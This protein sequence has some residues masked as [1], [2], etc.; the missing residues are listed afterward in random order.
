[1]R[2]KVDKQSLHGFK[3]KRLLKL[4]TI[5]RLYGLIF[6]P[7][8]MIIVEGGRDRGEYNLGFVLNL[9]TQL[10]YLRLSTVSLVLQFFDLH[11]HLV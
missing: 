4:N 1:M 5:Q 6:F 11:L 9:S 2:R 3:F 7:F 8:D 10:I